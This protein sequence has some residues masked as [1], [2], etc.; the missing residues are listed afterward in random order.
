MT[1][2]DLTRY[3]LSD[4]LIL[5]NKISLMV[6]TAIIRESILCF[7]IPYISTAKPV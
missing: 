4:L 2:D 3:A 5:I 1:M 7:L 6:V